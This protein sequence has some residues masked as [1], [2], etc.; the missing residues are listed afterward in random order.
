MKTFT[1]TC[2][3]PYDRHSYKIVLK[4][5]KS[6]QFDNYETMKYHWYQFREH[7]ERVEIIDVTNTNGKGF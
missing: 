6:I 5:G 7:T 1:A 3:K 2:N 4:N